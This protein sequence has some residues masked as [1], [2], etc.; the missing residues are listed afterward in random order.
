MNAVSVFRRFFDTILRYLP[1]FLTVLH[2]IGYPQCPPLKDVTSNTIRW[3]SLTPNNIKTIERMTCHCLLRPIGETLRAALT[4]L[5][6][7]I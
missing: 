4:L 1:I 3:V 2:G 6:R 5:T 7:R